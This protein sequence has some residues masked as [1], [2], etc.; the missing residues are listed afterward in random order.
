MAVTS[1]QFQL[2]VCC[3]ATVGLYRDRLASSHTEMETFLANYML[4]PVSLSV[5]CL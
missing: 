5:V 3:L 1:F 4:S 2:Q